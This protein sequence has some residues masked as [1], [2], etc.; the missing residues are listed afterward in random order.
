MSELS[1]SYS[2]NQKVAIVMYSDKMNHL[3][4]Q[5]FKKI[6]NL[7]LSKKFYESQ[8]ILN[9]I[10]LINPLSTIEHLS[11]Y[12]YSFEISKNFFIMHKNRPRKKKEYYSENIS[13]NSINNNIYIMKLSYCIKKMMKY[14]NNY[15]KELKLDIKKIILSKIYQY[16]N[17][18]HKEK[19]FLLEYYFISELSENEKYIEIMGSNMQA[20]IYKR[21]Y[22]LYQQLNK[23]LTEQ[24]KKFIKNIF[25]TEYETLKKNFIDESFNLFSKELKED[26]NCYLISTHWI[27]TFI[28]YLNIISQESNNEEND[29]ELGELLFQFSKTF[30]LYYKPNLDLQKFFIFAPAYP[31]P[32]NNFNI[33]GNC[34]FWYD[35]K[36]GKEYTNQFLASKSV[37][38]SYQIIDE[39]CYNLLIKLFG[40]PINEITRKIHF[41]ERNSSYPEIE[42][43]LLKYKVFILCKSLLED[44]KLSHLNQLKKI[45]ISKEETFNHLITKIIR[46]INYEVELIKGKE[47]IDYEIQRKMKFQIIIPDFIEQEKGKNILYNILDCYYNKYSSLIGKISGKEISSD[48]LDKKLEEMKIGE[49]DVI[50]IE[51]LFNQNDNFFLNVKS[52]E[53]CIKCS[54]CSITINQLVYKC[55]KCNL[56]FYCSEKCRNEDKKHI[57]H[58]KTLDELYKKKYGLHDLLS[59]DIRTILNPKSNHGL[60]G[61]KNLGNTCFMNSAI[62]CL[63]SVE[64][65]TKY[66]LLKKYLE[67]I[68]KTNKTGAK[69]K[70]A[71]AYYSLISEL[72]NGNER[73]IN[74]WDF[75]HI[76][77]SFVKQ[78][79]GFSQ[80]DS[81][82]M[83]TFVLDSLH[84]DLNRVKI[85]PY[86]ELKEKSEKETE[87]EASL[88]WW[89]NHI[90]RENS[91]IV[92][93]FHGQFKSVV[94]CPEC[95][96]VSTIYDPFM[97]LGLPIPSAQSKMRIKF[98][99]ENEI[100]NEVKELMFF[101]KCDENTTTREIKSKLFDDIKNSKK[102]LL[103]NKNI[104]INIEGIII[105]KNKKYKK[106]LEDDNESITA[107]YIDDNYEAL[108]YA[109]EKKNTV[110]NFFQCFITP[111]LI[112]N[113][114]VEI[115][116]YPKI[117]KFDTN[118]SVKEM[119][120]Y[121]FKYYRKYF[122]DIKN[123]SY[124]NFLE[125]V[126]KDNLNE[127]NKEFNE[128]FDMNETIPF[129]LNIEN[130]VPKKDKFSCEYCNRSC[131]YCPFNFK[132]TDSLLKVKQSQ[133]IKRPFLIY[134][135]ILNYSSRPFCDKLMPTKNFSKD[136]LIKSKEITIYDCFEAFRTEEKLEKDNSW[137]CSNCK[138]NQEA[139][140]KL[141]I[142]RAPNILIVQLKRF[143]CKTENIYEGLIKNKK[144]E[145]LVIFPLQNLD[146]SKYVV[147]ENS[148][149]DC[150]YDLCAISQHYG[151]LSS[152]HYTAFCLNGDEWYN[153]DD[154][155]VSKISNEKNVV[156]KGAYI[157]IFRKKSLG[158]IKKN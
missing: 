153:F 22:V 62:Q 56:Y 59:V 139:F 97:N 105:D 57:N 122:K 34:N 63:S 66:F 80:Q 133:K 154:E 86:S 2:S 137:Y 69:G 38:N 94:K 143:D 49:E 120:F 64:E 67:E 95:D 29:N 19:E 123:Y 51:F 87:E 90:E 24:K 115:L 107:N 39:Y 118:Y 110:Q 104:S 7:I 26:D 146:I 149:K 43:H 78:F 37:E 96:K 48:D 15:N 45:Q 3:T 61:L 114:I 73:Y 41:K 9:L 127:I 44:E 99:D 32:L 131:K 4:E 30:N 117:F 135:E 55:D 28:Y 33:C 74:P 124:E 148:R 27:R 126:S 145:S 10:S 8:Q 42:T 84:E 46:A 12:F 83:L 52:N 134:L 147:E 16:C 72:W 129:K 142:Y 128:Y 13:S 91:I 81:D 58:H 1:T 75:R 89:K 151:S 113:E 141:E 116:F 18:I 111:V 119:Y 150:L 138:K 14:F 98:L 54:L 5:M 121:I 36:E 31:G 21:K 40:R 101:Y 25:S 132:F 88:R 23:E 70:I 71:E 65:L 76:F 53:D 92:D 152:G 68:N 130:N 47:L 140:K 6:D 93:L 20:E 79:A 102:D 136:L 109:I 158:R 82:E 11:L 125:N 112:T 50:I 85:K 35:P 77:V 60:T 106:Y 157:L 17:I 156:S 144:N 103:N 108:F 100:K 155:K